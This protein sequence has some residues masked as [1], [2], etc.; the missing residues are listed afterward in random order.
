MQIIPLWPDH[1]HFQYP[2]AVLQPAPR[3]MSCRCAARAALYVYG[4]SKASEAS[5]MAGE[6]YRAPFRSSLHLSRPWMLTS[7]IA[8]IWR[9]LLPRP[10]RRRFHAG[11]VSLWTMIHDELVAGVGRLVWLGG[12][13]LWLASVLVSSRC[14][15]GGWLAGRC[16]DWLRS[17]LSLRCARRADCAVSIHPPRYAADRCASV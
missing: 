1:C 3:P 2:T 6:Q 12:W 11:H 15:L 7:C 13:V 8:E 9:K 17:W 14:V 4:P 16:S 10:R 5:L